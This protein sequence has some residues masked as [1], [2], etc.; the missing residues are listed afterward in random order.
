MTQAIPS[1]PTPS[2]RSR[3]ALDGLTFFLAD[4]LDGLGPY[5]AIYLAT[6]QK[7]TSGRIG[8]AM[9]SIVIGTLIAQMPVGAFIDRTKYKRFAIVA[10]ACVVA[11]CCLG[12]IA[13]PSFPVIVACQALIG[14]AASVMPPAIAGISLGLVGRS[15]LSRRTGRNEAFNHGGNM[16]AAILAGI[17][18]TYIGYGSIFVLVAVMAMASSICTLFIRESEIDHARASASASEDGGQ[19]SW[20]ELFSKPMLQIFLVAMFL[21][22]FANAAML[23]LVGQKVAASQPDIAAALMSACIIA[24]QLVMISVALI[25]ARAVDRWGTKL[26]FLVAMTVL[27]IRGLLFTLSTS[28]PY[29]IGVQLLDGIGAGIYGVVG[30]LV[31]ADLV[32]GT[33]RYNLALSAM[34]VAAGVGA[35]ASN[36]TIGWVS[37]WGGLDA[38]F[39]TLAGVAAIALVWFAVMFRDRSEPSS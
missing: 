16:T 13:A 21:F 25:A 2:L 6:S 26:I 37:D 27:P 15:H 33:G 29:L 4:V 31:I 1:D 3:T 19:V 22:H 10:A 7:W 28:A 39:A 36:L 35:A 23:P 30:V 38:G 34:A 11:G 24:A 12:M 9:A 14:A 20:R 32:A 18:G 8:I 17:V 5:L